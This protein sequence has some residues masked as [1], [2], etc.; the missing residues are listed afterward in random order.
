MA[1]SHFTAVLMIIKVEPAKPG[2]GRAY[3]DKR[4]TPD[5]DT[6]LA[7]IVVRN[8]QLESLKE[9]VQAHLDQVSDL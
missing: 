3:D 5:K 1:K 6:E 9:Q 4:G 7:S 2:S 8:S